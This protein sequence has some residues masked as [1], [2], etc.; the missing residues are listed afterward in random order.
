M[1]FVHIVLGALSVSRDSSRIFVTLS[2]RYDD[3]T[4]GVYA[5]CALKSLLLKVPHFFHNDTMV[6]PT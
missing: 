5:I 2:A 1:V 6:S 4:L 3:E